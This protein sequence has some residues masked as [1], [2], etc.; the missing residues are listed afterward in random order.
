V[1]RPRTPALAAPPLALAA[2]A[3]ALGCHSGYHTARA[4]PPGQVA[5]MAST[6]MVGATEGD[7]DDTDRQLNDVA[8][9][10]GAGQSVE[11]G[12]RYTQLR[13]AD[14]YL[15]EV[16]VEAVPDTLAIVVPF[17]FA[18]GGGEADLI[19]IHPTVVVSARQGKHV[20][21]TA[22]FRLSLV[23]V[24]DEL[25]LFYGLSA[26]VRLSSDLDRWA[27]QPELGLT[28]HDEIEGFLY[29]LGVAVIFNL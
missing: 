3:L 24:D 16:K 15:A 28:D 19:Q 13:E 27:I 20:E 9:R 6:T 1:T 25:E 22:S 23:D 18:W 14:N 26:G 5:V 4:L 10:V 21:P 8:V 12:L 17:G 7:E 29:H 2:A 11:V